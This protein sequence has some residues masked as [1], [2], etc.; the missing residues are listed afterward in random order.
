MDIP[1][2]AT[3]EE[4]LSHNANESQK[5]NCTMQPW[6]AACRL[7][8]AG[9]DPKSGARLKPERTLPPGL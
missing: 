9:T 7:P 2:L 8:A 1:A 6:A 5:C 4:G 3:S